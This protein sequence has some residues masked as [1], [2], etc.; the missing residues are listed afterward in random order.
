MA[1]PKVLKDVKKV[2]DLVYRAE[3]NVAW[4]IFLTMASVMFVYATQRIF[5][6][7]EGRLSTLLLYALDAM[8]L[9]PDPTF[10]HGSVSLTLNVL[11]AFGLSYVAMRTRV[12][13]KKKPRSVPFDLARAAGIT[14]LM[15]GFI[16]SILAIFPNG[17]AW[18]PKVTLCL[19]LWVGFIGA[20]M[21]AFEKRH[22]AVEIGEKI[23]PPSLAGPMKRLSFVCTTV[24]CAFIFT[25]AVQSVSLYRDDWIQ[26]NGLAGLIDTTSIPRWVVLL[27]LPYSFGMM[28]LRFALQIFTKLDAGGDEALLVALGAGH[29]TGST[30]GEKREGE[31]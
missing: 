27:V 8:G 31:T 7:P 26:S 17:L 19:L 1:W 13:D 5:S 30:S 11:I 24:F 9:S 12:E 21:S 28:G 4:V 6:R 2:D 18:G 23:W 16:V 15:T 20:S 29:L 14:A 22:L 25:L 3:R 10:V